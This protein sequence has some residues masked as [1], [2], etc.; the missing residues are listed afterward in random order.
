MEALR[1]QA[2]LLDL[3]HD[4]MLIRIRPRE[5]HG[6]PRSSDRE[7][8]PVVTLRKRRPFF[9]HAAKKTVSRKVVAKANQI[10]LTQLIDAHA[11]DQPR[12][13]RSRSDVK[14]NQNS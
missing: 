2:E 13:F 10:V 5:L 12:P 3:A 14:Y 9:L 11:N 1:R 7:R 4:A 6:M 8:M